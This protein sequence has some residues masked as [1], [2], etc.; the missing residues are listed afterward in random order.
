MGKRFQKS[1]HKGRRGE[2]KPTQKPNRL[3]P[4]KKEKPETGNK[5]QI[6]PAQQHHDISPQT[7]HRRPGLED[8]HIQ[9]QESAKKHRLRKT[10]RRRNQK[11]KNEVNN[12]MKEQGNKDQPT[13]QERWNNVKQANETA[14]ETVLGYKKRSRKS[15][16]EEIKKL[17]EE[18]K[19][20]NNKLNIAKRPNKKR[21][22]KKSQKHQA[23]QDPPMPRGRKTRKTGR[24]NRRNRKIE[25]RLLQNV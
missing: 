8:H 23:Q 7:C 21:R 6:V 9:R 16:N 15:E 10:K 4:R 19:A 22:N 12:I 25:R 1:H 24:A 17:S 18:Q 5:Q 20:L 13:P 11:Y 3:H 14:A 2:K